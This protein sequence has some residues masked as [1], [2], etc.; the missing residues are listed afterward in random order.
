MSG[1]VHADSDPD[2]TTDLATTST[3]MVGPARKSGD[4]NGKKPSWSMPKLKSW[5]KDPL[6]KHQ[7]ARP[8]THGPR[9]VSPERS[10]DTSN[11]SGVQAALRVPLIENLPNTA[12]REA[13]RQIQKDTGTWV[14]VKWAHHGKEDFI[15]A[16][17]KIEKALEI[18]TSILTLRDLKQPQ[19]MLSDVSEISKVTDLED[20]KESREQLRQLHLNLG[21]LQRDRAAKKMSIALFE[22]SRR[23]WDEA[24]QQ[25]A[26]LLKGHHGR[27]LWIQLSDSSEST[28]TCF[29]LAESN[30]NLSSRHTSTFPVVESLPENRQPNA[31]EE[32]PNAFRFLGTLRHKEATLGHTHCLFADRQNWHRKT[33]LRELL[34]RGDAVSDLLTPQVLIELFRGILTAFLKVSV[35][36]EHCANLHVGSIAYFEA[37][38]RAIDESS[39]DWLLHPY[40]SFGFGEPAPRRRI[41]MESGPIKNPN[42][43]ILELGLLLFALCC[44]RIPD[45]DLRQGR[46]LSP[47]LISAKRDALEKLIEIETR[48]NR[49]FADVVSAC[50]QSTAETQEKTVESALW[51]LDRLQE[52]LTREESLEH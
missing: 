51:I 13:L 14:H 11:L 5:I 16:I 46:H 8:T 9:I 32:G 47:K 50:L 6:R 27:L 35:V 28:E 17:E 25:E 33:T 41:G 52:N 39:T 10:R 12:S 42:A 29:I 44:R 19:R 36:A 24:A 22:D 43:A 34:G 49:R 3:S 21:Q 7:V 37:K 30:K 2:P 4:Q 38:D 15:A 20:L 23:L 26:G 48:Y 18:L 45:Y 31:V 1:D 40:F